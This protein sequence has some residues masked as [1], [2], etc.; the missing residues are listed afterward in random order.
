[1]A[2]EEYPPLTEA[3]L[4]AWEER[5]RGPKDWAAD[6]V[7]H[8]IAE[9]R[10]LRRAQLEAPEY[11]AEEAAQPISPEE[12]AAR[13]RAARGSMAHVPGSVD[14]FLRRKYEDIEWEDRRWTEAD[15]EVPEN[16]KA[17]AP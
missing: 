13:I 17:T 2:L 4:D 14:D 16:Q 15:P 8:L 7:L 1:M 11:Q 6:D 10:R 5:A 3:E 9:I 12:R